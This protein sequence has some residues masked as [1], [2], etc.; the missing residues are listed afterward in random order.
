M[1]SVTHVSEKYS[2]F[3]N[4]VVK[5]GV[6]I[7]HF[8]R[9]FVWDMESS[10]KLIDSMIKGYPI[11]TFILWNTTEELRSVRSIGNL[12]FPEQRI[13]EPVYYILDG[14]QRITSFFAAI[15]GAIVKREKSKEDDFSEIYIDLLATEDEE[16]VITEVAGRAEKSYIKINDLIHGTISFFMAF[17]SEYHDLLSAYKQ[18][19]TSWQ[20]NITYLNDAAIDV[21]TDV[22]TRLNVGGKTLTLFEIMVAKTYRAERVEV[23]GFDLLDKYN[24]LVAELMNSKYETI[25]NSTVLQVVSMLMVGGCTR[26]QILTLEK[27]DFIAIWDKAMDAIKRT[28]DY[29]RTFGIPVSELLPYN[30]LIVPFSYF[31]YKH[32]NKPV[33]IMQKRLEDFFWRCSLGG[34]YS[35]GVENKLAKDVSKIDR[36]LGGELPYYEWRLNVDAEDLKLNGWFG[37]SRSFVK[38][39]LCLYVLQ[40]PKSFDNNYDVL[41]DNSWLKKSTSKNYH[42]FFPKA[43]MKRT[44]LDMD[45]WRVNHILNITI[46]DAYLNQRQIKDKA[47]KVYLGEIALH[48]EQLEETLR[49]HLI[50]LDGFGVKDNDY[51]RFFAG[52]A[53]LVSLEIKK[54][55]IE[56]ESGVENQAVND[57]SD[58]EEE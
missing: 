26:N 34:R 30:A 27:A 16:I 6:R 36:I 54:R 9:N 15:N 20:F 14:Q 40:K 48:N 51:E 41:I 22:F 29:F 7:P 53:E 35:S 8:Q 24:E 12:T 18:N 5:G 1:A 21:A 32:P 33:G 23:V 11:G 55:I 13:G 56:Q 43:Y 52:R 28:V 42:H 25:S 47:P 10:A 31:F 49:T 50:D 46:V 39:I 19:I 3:L 2:E 17:P 44:Y 57:E 4:K 58:E 45:Y 37:T 38:S